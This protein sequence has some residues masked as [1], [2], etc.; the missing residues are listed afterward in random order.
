MKNHEMR[1]L[2]ATTLLSVMVV[3]VAFAQQ[4][5][6]DDILNGAYSARSVRSVRPDRKSVV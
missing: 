2:L 5:K 3:M 4:I 1:R 6:L